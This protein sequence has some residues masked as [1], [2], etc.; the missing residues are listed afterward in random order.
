MRIV[1]DPFALAIAILF[2]AAA[3]Y[4]YMRLQRYLD[5][6]SPRRLYIYDPDVWDEICRDAAGNF[7]MRLAGFDTGRESGL[8]AEM[9]KYYDHIS[10]LADR[11]KITLI[12]R[13][14]GLVDGDDY[15]DA[16]RLPDAAG[17]VADWVYGKRE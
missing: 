15:I 10:A 6:R 3:I 11:E 14:K 12:L 7:I 9:P 16:A 2:I 4:G 8:E 5:K 1:I 13:E 17:I